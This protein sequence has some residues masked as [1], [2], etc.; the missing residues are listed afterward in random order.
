[1]R[2]VVS[3]RRRDTREKWAIAWATRMNKGSAWCLHRGGQGDEGDV[4]GKARSYKM[5]CASL[6]DLT[7]CEARAKTTQDGVSC[8]R[9]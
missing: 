7:L 9:W 8:Q 4:R 1:M 6:G 2:C 5:D 3:G